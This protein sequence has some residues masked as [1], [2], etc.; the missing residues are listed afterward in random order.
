ML[1][2][3]IIAIGLGLALAVASICGCSIFENK[4]SERE[5]A[6]SD[7]EDSDPCCICIYTD[8]QSVVDGMYYRQLEFYRT[9]DRSIKFID[10]VQDI[11]YMYLKDG[12]T[13]GCI[14]WTEDFSKAQFVVSSDEP[15]PDL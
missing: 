2:Q 14:G 6:E 10:H 4:I 12:Y 9:D 11:Q 1:V 15:I 8:E 13:V 5:M 7:E 3:K